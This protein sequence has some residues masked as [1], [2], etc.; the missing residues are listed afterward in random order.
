[1]KSN[2]DVF[3]ST[4]LSIPYHILRTQPKW[5]NSREQ[6]MAQIG[7][8]C[9]G[10]SISRVTHLHG[11]QVI[12]ILELSRQSDI[13]TKDGVLV[14]EVAYRMTIPANTKSKKIVEDQTEVKPLQED[15]WCLSI[16]I[17]LS[18]GQT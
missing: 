17:Q 5:A 3:I 2:F 12:R 9:M 6:Q 4:K 18:A 10:C 11:S 7:N 15:G 14:G 13:W 16:T 1:M 8:S